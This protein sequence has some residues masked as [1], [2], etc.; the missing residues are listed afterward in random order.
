MFNNGNDEEMAMNNTTVCSRRNQAAQVILLA[1]GTACA[2]PAALASSVDFRDV[3]FASANN[4][5]SYQFSVDGV[6]ITLSTSLQDAVLWWDD[7]DGFG[8]KSSAG[9][10]NDEIEGS[11]KLLVSFSK[12]VMLTGFSVSDLFHEDG[13][14]NVAFYHE[15]GLYD[16]GDQGSVTGFLAVE[17]AD[18]GERSVDVNSEL[19]LISFSAVGQVDW[20]DHEFALM[21]L[22]FDVIDGGPGPNPI[23]VPAAAWLL[24]SGLAGLVSWGRRST[25]GN[26]R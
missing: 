9:Y 10:E 4:Q 23:P 26:R 6:D 14:Q 7:E 22:D 1:L 17:G 24:A 18:N 12:P 3:S 21:G 2:A 15:M 25:A 11:E 19:E 13:Y 5:S 20:Q 16:V 8:V